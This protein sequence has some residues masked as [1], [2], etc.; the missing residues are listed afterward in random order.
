MAR[1]HK[2]RRS[3]ILRRLLTICFKIQNTACR[4]SCAVI[5]TTRTAENGAGWP[6][7][8]PEAVRGT[9]RGRKK[10]KATQKPTKFDT[11]SAFLYALKYRL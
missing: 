3:S 1:R 7:L 4:R 11:P 2:S 8:R 6:F 10:V 5:A 9:A